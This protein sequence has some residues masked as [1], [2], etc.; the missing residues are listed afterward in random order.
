MPY[1]L[2]VIC[3]GW[4]EAAAVL[5]NDG[6]IIA[7]AEEE[8]F[9]RKKFDNTFPEQSIAFC[10]EHAGIRPNELAA[11]GYGFNPRRKLFK[12]ALHVARYFPK[13]LNMLKTR[14]DLFKKMNNITSEIRE[15]LHFNGP[16]YRLNHHLGHAASTFLPSPFEESAIMAIDGAGD[17]ESC[18]WGA[19]R[20]NK[21]TEMGTLDW[22]LSLGHIYT[23][24]TEFLGFSAFSDE[25]KV[26]GL[27]PYGT[28]KFVREMEKIFWPTKD[29]FGVDFSYFNFPTGHFPRYGDKI[30][31][32]FGPPLKD[33]EEVPQHFRDVAA[34]V[35]A[36]LEVIIC[37]LTRMVVKRTGLKT[38]CLAGGVG[39]NCVANGKLI[40]EKIVERVFVP[41]CAS[42]AGVA[43][44]AAYLAHL[45]VAKGLNR[46]P[47]ESALLGAEYSSS[48]I[49][50]AIRCQGLEPQKIE[51]PS[52][53][54]A[55]LLS[56]GKVIGW[57]QGRFE[58]GQRALGARSIL[59]DPR[60][61]EMKEII[62]RKVKFRE[63]FRPFAPSVL[64][65]R[66]S[67]FFHCTHSVPFM[68][69]VYPVREEKKSII[70]A[71]THEDGTARLQTVSKKVNPLYWELIHR[72][73]ELTGVPVVLN[74]SFNVKGQPIVSTPAQAVETFLNTDIDA[75]VCGNFL[76]L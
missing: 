10:L 5:I 25:Y 31:A 13:S 14:G 44:G 9:S 7:A 41:P 65:E 42:D 56:E 12:K 15:K 22:P 75:L 19:G 24:F 33:T 45:K 60:K 58:F 61:A 50:R 59:A 49:E 54:A 2:G 4:H 64:E 34:S 51:N 71:V 46:R 18:W 52:A 57:F 43:L 73:G 1:V 28:P 76:V 32:A 48:E 30:V 21:I 27:A 8:R 35:Q 6:E 63:P 26:M 11:I 17:W 66:A 39:M 53:T 69:E 40:S 37:H 38:I 29:G 20:G 3:Y 23:A 70:P 68:T 55:Q 67:E 62:N 74:T 36:Q 16:V 47:M 72:F